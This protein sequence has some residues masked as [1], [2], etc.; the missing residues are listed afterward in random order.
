MKREE[1][2]QYTIA[3]YCAD[4]IRGEYV[5][6]GAVVQSA[7]TH[8][9]VG[10]FAKHLSRLHLHDPEF[11]VGSLSLF[12]DIFKEAIEEGSGKAGFLPSLV[13]GAGGMLSFTPLRGGVTCNSI[14]TTAR[15]IFTQFVGLDQRSDVVE[16]MRH[17][18]VRLPA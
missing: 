12:L 13:A 17:L 14:E 9:V 7:K 2:Y 3:R 15:E 11:C 5:N 6:I 10:V 16:G 8:H 1:G 4:E 18:L